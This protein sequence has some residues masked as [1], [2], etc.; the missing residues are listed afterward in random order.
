MSRIRRTASVSSGVAFTRCCDGTTA[1]VPSGDSNSNTTWLA[2]GAP[3]NNFSSRSS[4]PS[5]I[6]AIETLTR[7]SSCAAA[8]SAMSAIRRASCSESRVP[9]SSICTLT[10]NNSGVPGFSVCSCFAKLSGN[11]SNSCTPVMS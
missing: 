8:R 5:F 7:N 9:A 2:P 3:A 11:A 10:F 4:V 6:E 1:I